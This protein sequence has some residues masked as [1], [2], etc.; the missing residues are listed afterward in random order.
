MDVTKITLK[1]LQWVKSTMF[2]TQAI[3]TACYAINRLYLHRI[4]KKTSYVLLTSK[5]NLNFHFDIKFISNGYFLWKKKKVH[6]DLLGPHMSLGPVGSPP[7]QY[8][9]I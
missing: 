9:Q 1:E 6:T 7:N 4:I 2:W 8:Y 3:N 5:K